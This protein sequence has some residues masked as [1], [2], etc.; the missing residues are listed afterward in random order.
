MLF[1]LIASVFIAVIG[2]VMIYFGATFF[3]VSP[4]QGMDGADLRV[5]MKGLPHKVGTDG[6]DINLKQ[7]FPDGSD[8]KKD[9]WKFNYKFRRYIENK[10]K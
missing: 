6:A 5:D 4:T 7:M 3:Q 8:F 1:A 2:I 10:S 9:W